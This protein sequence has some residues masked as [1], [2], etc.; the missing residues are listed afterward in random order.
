MVEL[1][2]YDRWGAQIGT[3]TPITCTLH[4]ISKIDPNSDGTITWWNATRNINFVDG[5][6]TVCNF[7]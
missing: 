3:V 1:L 2:V 4:Y 5:F 6:C 7:D